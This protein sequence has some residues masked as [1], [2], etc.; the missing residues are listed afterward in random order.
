MRDLRPMKALFT[1]DDRSRVYSL[2]DK[3]P[4][5]LVLAFIRKN[6]LHDIE[7]W[8]RLARV[9]FELDEQFTYAIMAF[10]LE[11]LQSEVVWPDK[12]K[13]KETPPYPFRLDDKYWKE[14]IATD[15]QVRNQIR[16]QAPDQIPKGMK[17]TMEVIEKWV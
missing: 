8:R 2:L 1:W 10:C 3:Y 16:I 15:P 14:I 7:L 5:P 17:K 4:I 13:V 11:P 12:T 9:G 6:R